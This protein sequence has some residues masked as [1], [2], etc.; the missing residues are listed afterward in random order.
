MS[1]HRAFREGFNFVT[2]YLGLIS[3]ETPDANLSVDDRFVEM[4]GFSIDEIYGIDDGEAEEE[5]DE[6]D[7]EPNLFTPP[8]M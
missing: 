5:E 8:N 7:Y 4:Y 1:R 3:T 6:D 2:D